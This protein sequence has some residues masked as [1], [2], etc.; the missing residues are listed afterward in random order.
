MDTLPRHRR[1]RRTAA[2]LILVSVVWL[3]VFS[4]PVAARW[5][6]PVNTYH[7]SGRLGVNSDLL[8][9]SG[10]SAWAIDRWLAAHT[11]LPKLGAAF[12]KA[13][14]RYG[15]NARYLLAHAMLESGFGTSD[16]ARY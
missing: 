1:G 13:E 4:A 5:G 6:L 3:G 11:P 12:M 9:R 16:I 7:A 2:L 15:V 10:L 8:S 14:R